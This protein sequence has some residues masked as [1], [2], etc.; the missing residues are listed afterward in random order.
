MKSIKK[1]ARIAGIMFLI[2]VLTGPF[3]L[4]YVPSQLIVEGDAAA[5]TGNIMTSVSLFQMG[6]LGH[7]IILFADIG[8]AVL[9]YILLKPVNN[10]F[11]L[12]AM[13]FRLIMVAI[14]G[15]NLVNYFII[16][17]LINGSGD[18]SAFPAEH[19]YA[20]VMTYLTAFDNG[21]LLDMIF[22]SVH[23]L[24]L[25]ILVYKSGFI[26][27][28]FGVLLIIAF[29]GYLINSLTGLFVPEYYTT[30]NQIVTVPNA[31]SELALMLWLLIRGV[32]VEK[33]EHL[34]QQKV[35]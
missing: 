22:F 31:V 9:L 14:R 26:P 21:V 10:M 15:S 28:I 3:S 29:F 34:S 13:V 2:M 16:L 25:G 24:F 30:V 18:M 23:L 5:T 11:A 35:I 17:Q 1:T 4:M 32:N 7:L 19:L 12:F 33:R 8:V 27:R 20:L 6:I